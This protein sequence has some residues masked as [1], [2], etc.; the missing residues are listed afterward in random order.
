MLRLRPFLLASGVALALLTPASGIRTPFPSAHAASPRQSSGDLT[1]DGNGP[2]MRKVSV[3]NI[4]WLPNGTSFQPP[5]SASSNQDYM[6]IVNQFFQDVGGSSWY[7][8]LTQYGGPKAKIQNDVTLADAFVDTRA[9]PQGKGSEA[10]PLLDSDLQKEIVRVMNSRHW[11]NQKLRSI[12]FIYTANGIQSCEDTP[13]SNSN[14]C[15]FD[16]QNGYCGYHSYFTYKKKTVL[17]ANA[18]DIF[19]SQY[20]DGN[21]PTTADTAP[22]ADPAADIQVNNVAHEL[23]EAATD[24]LI[25]AWGGGAAGG[26]DEVGDLCST[27]FLP[28]DD[29]GG[30]LVISNKDEYY[31]Q[32]LYSNQDGGCVFRLGGALVPNAP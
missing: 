14:T 7:S 28:R 6:D 8:V 15:T 32:A 26:Q 11:P 18:P 16:T 30:D 21:D 4:F 9:Y 1:N 2:V 23:A 20:C 19:T 22:N 10:K 29:N 27:A 31:I 17:Y 25:N 12:F 24:P 3:Y 5:G 13:G